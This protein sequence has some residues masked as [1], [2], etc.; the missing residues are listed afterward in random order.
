MQV[1]EGV[2]LEDQTLQD[3]IKGSQ[4][5]EHGGSEG[6]GGGFAARPTI[7]HIFRHTGR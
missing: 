7:D 5:D 3:G 4:A 6:G 2:G 1:G